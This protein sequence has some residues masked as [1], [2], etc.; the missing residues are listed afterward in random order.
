MCGC[1]DQTELAP[2]ELVRFSLNLEP[3]DY[4]KSLNQPS[5]ALC[6]LL[7]ENNAPT[8]QKPYK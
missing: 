5:N 4:L 7:A 3:R 1:G 6:S 8:N 2:S